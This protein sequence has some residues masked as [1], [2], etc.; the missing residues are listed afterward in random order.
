M[1]SNRQ[2]QISSK[3]ILF[4]IQSGMR[5]LWLHLVWNPIE[6]AGVHAGYHVESETMGEGGLM[7]VIETLDVSP[8]RIRVD[9]LDLYLG[10]MNTIAWLILRRRWECSR[11]ISGF[12]KLY[13]QRQALGVRSVMNKILSESHIQISQLT[14]QFGALL[15]SCSGGSKLFKISPKMATFFTCP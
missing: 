15:R 14:R 7:L 5:K 12:M 6:D 8:H 13:L 3:T 9:W 11:A 1:K 4:F 2:V 10:R